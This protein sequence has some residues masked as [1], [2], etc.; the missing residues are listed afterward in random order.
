MQHD[1]FANPTRRMQASYPFLVVLQAN[2]VGGQNRIVAPLAPVVPAQL[3]QSRALLSVRHE[4][5]NYVV[6]MTLLGFFP[7]RQLRNPVGSLGAYRDDLSRALDWIF[8]GI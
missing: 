8:F 3:P 4:D 1:L 5:R 2:V 7:A 6:M